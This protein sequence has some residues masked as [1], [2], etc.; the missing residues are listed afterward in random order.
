MSKAPAAAAAV[1]PAASRFERL[2]RVYHSEIYPLFD[3]WFTDPLI[4]VIAANP[5]TGT[6][7]LDASAGAGDLSAALVKQRPARLVAMDPGGA[8][9]GLALEHEHLQTGVTF[10]RGGST[11]SGYPFRNAAFDRV[12]ARA[13]ADGAVEP[14]FSMGELVRVCK[15]AGRIDFTAAVKGTW[16]EPLDL[17][18]EAL[19]RR[20][21]T[22]ARQALATYQDRFPSPDTMVAGLTFAGLADVKIS[23]DRKQILFRSGREFF[24]SSLIELGPLRFWKALVGKGEP[25]QAVF[26][27]VKDAI[28]TYYAGRPFTVTACVAT[29]TG[30]RKS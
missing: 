18:N 19:E 13:R 21:E 9:L 30:R 15:P 25:L 10:A 27:S 1:R 16:A 23:I 2:T 6:D 22:A 4:E 28:D 5:V 11:S 3:H 26:A 17:L 29:V 24:F 20:G 8:M 14:L 7:V 12:F